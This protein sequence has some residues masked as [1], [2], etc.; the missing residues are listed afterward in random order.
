MRDGIG[1][2]EVGLLVLK[3]FHGFGEI[4]FFYGL[5]GNIHF[6]ELLLDLLNALLEVSHTRQGLKEFHIVVFTEFL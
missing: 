3:R 2:G 6:G 5:D 1:N 4:I